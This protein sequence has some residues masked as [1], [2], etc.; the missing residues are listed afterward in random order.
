MVVH[1]AEIG[2]K[3]MYSFIAW[4]YGDLERSRVQVLET[5]RVKNH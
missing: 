1:G 5:F 2:R 3:I 4:L